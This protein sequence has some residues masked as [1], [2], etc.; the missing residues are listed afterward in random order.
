MKFHVVFTEGSP[1]EPFKFGA[2]DQALTIEAPT[3]LGAAEKAHTVMG[4]APDDE[5]IM[6][7]APVDSCTTIVVGTKATPDFQVHVDKGRK[8][9]KV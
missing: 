3:P 4:L 7:V 1:T 9:N 5:G 6:V 2:A 8:P